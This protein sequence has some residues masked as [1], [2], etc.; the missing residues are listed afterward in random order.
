MNPGG[1]GA[2]GMGGRRMDPSKMMERM[3]TITLADL[4]AGDVIMVSSSG[5][6]DGMISA[7]SLV[8]GVEL[9]LTAPAKPGQAAGPNTSWNFEM[10]IPQ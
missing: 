1:M 10:S 2:G 8:A 5:M 4:K 6:K 9:L 7:I 3:P